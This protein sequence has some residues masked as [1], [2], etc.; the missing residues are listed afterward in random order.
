MLPKEA[1]A[2]MST[3]LLS[4]FGSCTLIAADFVSHAV[5]T[6]DAPE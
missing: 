5:R 3:V 1:S 4:G 6:L 2:D